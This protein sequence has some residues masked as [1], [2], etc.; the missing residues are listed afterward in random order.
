MTDMIPGALGFHHHP[1]CS[2]SEM[3]SLSYALHH[4]SMKTSSA[5]APS[6]MA[7]WGWSESS[8]WFPHPPGV[9]LW[10][11]CGRNEAQSPFSVTFTNSQT[12]VV[13]TSLFSRALW[14]EK[15]QLL[16]LHL[17]FRVN[18]FWHQLSTWTPL[19]LRVLS[20]CIS[21]ALVWEQKTWVSLSMPQHPSF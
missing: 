21:K 11:I 2:A 16:R 18:C 8:Q 10:K 14:S 19:M 13:P 3:S 9:L 12:L 1:L 7:P 6:A 17:L 4:W 5:L 15:N 20:S